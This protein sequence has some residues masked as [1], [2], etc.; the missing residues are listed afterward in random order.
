MFR[1]PLAV[2]LTATGSLTTI[3]FIGVPK[4]KGHLMNWT[5]KLPTE[6]GFYWCR[7]N[8]RT[9]MVH[10]WRHLALSGLFTNEDEASIDDPELYSNAMWYGPIFPPVPPVD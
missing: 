1:I 9:R 7:Q 10:V 5:E 2:I 8:E 3:V 6:L 4:T